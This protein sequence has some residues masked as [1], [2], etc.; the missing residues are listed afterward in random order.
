MK[1]SRRSLLTL[2]AG[3]VAAGAA[4]RVKMAPI[5]FEPV[6]FTGFV[7]NVVTIGITDPTHIHMSQFSGK[8]EVGMRVFGR[9]L[10]L[11]GAIITDIHSSGTI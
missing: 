4:S 1:T 10:P 9:G 5:E 2:L 3:A 11:E 8:L 6:E 7:P